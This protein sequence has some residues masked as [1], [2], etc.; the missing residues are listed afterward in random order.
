MNAFAKY[1]SLACLL[2]I[3]GGCGAG[4][5]FA[6]GPEALK[7]HG[8]SDETMVTTFHSPE[9]QL[10]VTLGARNLVMQTYQAGVDN[11]GWERVPHF[12]VVGTPHVWGFG[13]VTVWERNRLVLYSIHDAWWIVMDLGGERG[14]VLFYGWD[15]YGAGGPVELHLL[16][17][18]QDNS[19]GQQW[20]TFVW[21]PMELSERGFVL[22]PVPRADGRPHLSVEIV[23]AGKFVCVGNIL[24]H[25]D[26]EMITFEETDAFRLYAKE[27]ELP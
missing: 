6:I 19:S 26:L 7:A 4:T 1:W 18:S 8:I 12:V 5:D 3:L 21:P 11:C 9:Q 15:N 2:A 25:P 22:R 13:P 17:E 16:R 23:Q 20:L 24:S 14:A 27:Q 10:S